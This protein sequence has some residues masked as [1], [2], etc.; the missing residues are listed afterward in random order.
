VLKNAGRNWKQFLNKKLQ[1]IPQR[2]SLPSQA[3]K[4]TRI[5]VTL[6]PHRCIHHCSLLL[7]GTSLGKS[8]QSTSQLKTKA[9]QET[10]ETQSGKGQRENSHLLSDREHLLWGKKMVQL[11]VYIKNAKR[12]SKSKHFLILL[13]S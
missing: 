11:L 10:K 7:Q 2:M 12:K 13:R 6:C 1:R 8:Q 9:K 5:Q 3:S 4:P